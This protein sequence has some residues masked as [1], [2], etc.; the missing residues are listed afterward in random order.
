MKNKKSYRGQFFKIINRKKVSLVLPCF[1]AMIKIV[2]IKQAITKETFYLLIILKN[3]PRYDFL[4]FI[5]RNPIWLYFD[6]IEPYP[7]FNNT[8]LLPF[9]T[10]CD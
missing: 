1:I 8:I 5:K 9:G 2:A 6:S 7:L 4:F 10:R 3:C